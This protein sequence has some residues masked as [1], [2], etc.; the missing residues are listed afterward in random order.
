MTDPSVIRAL[1]LVILAVSLGLEVAVFWRYSRAFRMMPKCAKSARLTPLHV[2]LVSA[3]TLILQGTLAGALIDTFRQSSTPRA[4]FRLV[5]YGC[6]SLLIIASLVV[7]IWLQAERRKVQFGREHHTVT[8]IDTE[9]V[10][11]RDEESR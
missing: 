6:G 8:A 3:G 5:M 1:V 11:V 7:L 10:Q 4:V 2:A 9:T